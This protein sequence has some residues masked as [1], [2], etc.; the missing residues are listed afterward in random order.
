MAH[1]E[2]LTNTATSKA[3]PVAPGGAYSVSITSGSPTCKL[4]MSVDGTNWIDVLD[5]QGDTVQATSAAIAGGL[6]VGGL[7][8][9]NQTGTAVT[10][11]ALRGSPSP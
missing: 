3:V 8:R 1:T 5:S 11:I 7:Y 6:V 9:F 4:Q 10:E 2:T